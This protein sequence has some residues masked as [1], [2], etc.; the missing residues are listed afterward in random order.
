MKEYLMF[1]V[2]IKL[3]QLKTI[4]FALQYPVYLKVNIRKLHSFILLNTLSVS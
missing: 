1:D 3:L 4:I 2:T